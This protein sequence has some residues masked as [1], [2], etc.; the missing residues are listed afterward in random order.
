MLSAR[1]P[2][3][4]ALNAKRAQSFYSIPATHSN[5][6][7]T[8]KM[9]IEF[10]GLTFRQRIFAFI[11]CMFIGSL[12]FLYSF[13]RLLT[14]LINPAGF[15]LPYAFSNIIF[16]LMFGFLSGFRSYFTNLFSKNKRGFT[17]AFIISTVVTVYSTLF[18]KRYLL[19]LSLMFIQIVVF[20]CFTITFLPGG[21]SGISSI[22][23]MF[24]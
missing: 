1:D 10:F 20:I 9:D 12:L 7:K 17:T 11:I 5:F 8:Q 16:F 15:I 2:L 13:T 23:G 24:L 14:S 22:I 6:F 21:A 18:F 19:N 3:Q 4:E